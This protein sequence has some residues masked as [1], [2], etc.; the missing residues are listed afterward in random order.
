MPVGSLERLV[1][2][3]LMVGFEG[4]TPPSDLLRKVEQGRVGGVILFGRNLQDAEQTAHLTQM[5]QE[6]AADGGQP[7]LMIA[8]DHEG[9]GVQR[10][11]QGFTQLPSEM[12]MAASG[13]AA[14]VSTLYRQAAQ[15]L[16]AV[17]ININFAPVL[18]VNNNP[19]NPVIGLRSFGSQ[20]EPVARWGQTAVQ[21]WLDGGVIPCGKHFPGHG[22]TAQDSHLTLPQVAHP[23]DRLEAVEL[24]PFRAAVD[25]GLPALMTA[26][27]VF[28]ALEQ[29]RLP[30][31]L[32]RTI[33]SD[34]VRGDMGFTGVLFTDCLE[35]NAIKDTVGTVRGAVLAAIAGADVL[36]VSHTRTLQDEA[37]TALVNGVIAGEIPRYRV[38]A[39]VERISHLKRSLLV[40]RPAFPPSIPETLLQV[41]RAAVS[42]VGRLDRLPVPGCIALVSFRTGPGSF[43]EDKPSE[44]LPLAS[45]LGHSI[46]HHME[47]PLDPDINLVKSALNALPPSAVVVVLDRAWKHPTQYKLLSETLLL[48]PTYV[49]ALT[50]PFDLHGLPAGVVGITAFDN[51]APAQAVLAEALTGK[52]TVQQHWPVTLEGSS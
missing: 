43:A 26:H 7:P 33:L 29:A 51:T 44:A 4:L 50:S 47:F 18:D 1:G 37:Y 41:R 46:A 49:V 20:A 22:D 39:S 35:M 36:L 24:L 48:G 12:A 42:G 19:L 10:L 6:A 2:Q 13:D 32:S 38:E 40:Q 11:R 14:L 23:R 3:M 21:A 34:L 30:A 5:L 15:E 17:G 9:G 27:I 28:P 8:V 52:I 31:T 16:A 25:G 45:A